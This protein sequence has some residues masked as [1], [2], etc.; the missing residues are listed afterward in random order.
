M[1][2]AKAFSKESSELTISISTRGTITSRTTVSEKSST[3]SISSCSYSSTTSGVVSRSGTAYFDQNFTKG[4]NFSANDSAKALCPRVRPINCCSN[5][6]ATKAI[7]RTSAKGAWLEENA[8]QLAAKSTNSNVLAIE[9]AL[10][11]G[12]SMACR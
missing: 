5:Q 2:T 8:S 4:S 6:S 12:S 9:I 1:N 10:E 3:D 11:R 7:A